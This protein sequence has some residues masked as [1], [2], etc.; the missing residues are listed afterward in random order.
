MC[1][2]FWNSFLILCVSS[3]VFV[4]GDG[5][6]QPKRLRE[7]APLLIGRDAQLFSSF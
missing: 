1:F 6:S 2:S 7:F 5:P 3:I 4:V